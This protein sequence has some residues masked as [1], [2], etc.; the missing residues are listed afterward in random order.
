MGLATLITVEVRTTL[1]GNRETNGWQVMVLS[2][3]LALF[4]NA[5]RE[6]FGQFSSPT[7][8]ALPPGPYVVWAV[9]PTDA[10]VRGQEKNVTLGSVASGTPSLAP[11]SMDILV[12]KSLR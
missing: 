11:V 4:P 3:P 1:A 10:G 7:S 5:P 9:D 12:P 8:R 6:A 2:A